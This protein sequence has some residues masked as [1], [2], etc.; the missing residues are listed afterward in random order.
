MAEKEEVQEPTEK[1]KDDTPMEKNVSDE[2]P[3]GETPPTQEASAEEGDGA[4]CPLLVN[5]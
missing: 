5:V 3:V 2:Q 4:L 1:P